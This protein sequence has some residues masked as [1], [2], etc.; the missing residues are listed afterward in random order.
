MYPIEERI[1]ISAAIGLLVAQGWKVAA[2]IAH[3]G[4]DRDS[5]ARWLDEESS[6]LAAYKSPKIWLQW[7]AAESY[8]PGSWRMKVQTRGPGV[9]RPSDAPK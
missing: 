2:A 6:C 9:D 8:T 5:L 1:R 7:L 4:I 3:H